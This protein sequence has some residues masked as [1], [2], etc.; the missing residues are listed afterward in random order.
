M[1]NVDLNCLQL[2]NSDNNLCAQKK[3][4]HTQITK[5]NNKSVKLNC[6]VDYLNERTKPN[7]TFGGHMP[8]PPPPS[9]SMLSFIRVTTGLCNICARAR[10]ISA[11]KNLDDCFT[12]C[13]NI[14]WISLIKR[15]FGKLLCPTPPGELLET[16]KK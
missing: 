3:E 16:L 6:F 9:L 10:G 2:K 7:P 5:S 14:V 13:E 11:D 12:N 4:R 1:I 8:P 15:M